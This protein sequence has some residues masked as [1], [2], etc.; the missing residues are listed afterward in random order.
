MNPGRPQSVAVAF[1]RAW[2]LWLMAKH[3][4]KDRK[5][6]KDR[7]EHKQ[8]NLLTAALKKGQADSKRAQSAKAAD[9]EPLDMVSADAAGSRPAEAADTK[10]AADANVAESSPR[11]LGGL[12]DEKE[13]SRRRD[14]DE[15]VERAIR[16]KCSD[17][18]HAN[19]E[20]T[21]VAGLTLRQRVSK[22]LAA[23]LA[24]SEKTGKRGRL[25][26]SYWRQILAD[27][28]SHESLVTSLHAKDPNSPKPC[29]EFR[30]CMSVAFRK[31]PS[32]RSSDPLFQYLANCASLSQ[33]E[34]V[35]L[36]KATFDKSFI[37]RHAQDSIYLEVLRCLVRLDLMN[38]YSEEVS[39]LKPLWDTALVNNYE[40]M[41]R[42]GSELK[43]WVTGNLGLC[44][45]VCDKVDLEALLQVSDDH[46]GKVAPI[47]ARV[48]S[49]SRLGHVLYQHAAVKICSSHLSEDLQQLVAEALNK[50]YS[51]EALKIFNTAA[52]EKAK[53]FTRVLGTGKRLVQ[54]RLLDTDFEMRVASLS[55]EAEARVW[56]GIKNA[57]LGRQKGL[58]LMMHERLLA[59]LGFCDGPCEV[60]EEV[61]A[62][63]RVAREAAI[64]MIE[65]AGCKSYEE[66]RKV[67]LKNQQPLLQLDRSFKVEIDWMMQA[68]A[69]LEENTDARLLALLPPDGSHDLAEALGQLA[70]WL[71]S[72]DSRFVAHGSRGKALALQEMLQRLQSGT[73]PQASVAVDSFWKAV[74]AKLPY[75][76]NVKRADGEVLRG[77]AAMKEQLQVCKAKRDEGSL[78][79]GDLDWLQALH[80]AVSPDESRFIGECAKHCLTQLGASSKDSLPL[81]AAPA[82]SCSKPSKRA[83]RGAEAVDDDGLDA[84][85]G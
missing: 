66:V 57:S 24:T 58:P 13:P 83:R 15:L 73:G 8:E 46:W 30:R 84:Y 65:D 37:G 32:S 77:P 21:Q 50:S 9:A 26:A 4:R 5:E 60:D 43:R 44:G 6:K 34:L 61:L 63:M 1:L 16:A 80:Y 74:L 71:D 62:P 14:F 67:L 68:K 23:L 70:S 22:D 85:F 53:Q 28:S 55:N 29:E 78:N 27:Y 82:S 79:M 40:H 20:A 33:L 31:N 49:S 36:I 48:T 41:K 81:R 54:M 75:F 10:R 72:P 45:V 2:P 56:A 11:D 59:P 76:M 12:K 25:S 64:S 19:I 7:K 42:R 17:L 3:E 69:K 38:A 52:A 35:G 18:T 47:I 39:T 51:A